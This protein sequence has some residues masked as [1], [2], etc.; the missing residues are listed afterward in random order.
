MSH[1]FVV[2]I[3]D[4]TASR[5]EAVYSTLEGAIA[6]TKNKATS[7]IQMEW[8]E[9]ED[10]GGSWRLSGVEIPTPNELKAWG[11]SKGQRCEWCIEQHEVGA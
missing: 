2:W 8:D 11:V 5:V 10:W 9:V 6:G 3:V 1:V 4:Y 7:R